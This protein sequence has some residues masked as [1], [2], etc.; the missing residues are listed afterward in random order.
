MIGWAGAKINAE[1]LEG[2]KNFVMTVLVL[3]NPKGAVGMKAWSFSRIFIRSTVLDE[4]LF[5]SKAGK[6]GSSRAI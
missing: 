2:I 1:V 3:L 6:E 5:K 4:S